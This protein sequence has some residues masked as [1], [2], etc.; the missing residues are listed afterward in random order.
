[1]AVVAVRA[2]LSG[3]LLTGAAVVVGLAVTV[4]ADP[5]AGGTAAAPAAAVTGAPAGGQLLGVARAGGGLAIL[6]APVAGG[7]TVTLPLAP[8]ARLTLHGRAVTAAQLAA[9]VRA[10]SL[11]VVR[12]RYGPGGAVL[13]VAGGRVRQHGEMSGG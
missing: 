12:L 5:A 4:A 10:G 1:M 8:D 9:S 2:A 6:V 7:P 13:Q 11:P 3:L